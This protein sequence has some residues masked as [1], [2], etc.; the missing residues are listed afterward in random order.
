MLLTD[1]KHS[2]LQTVFKDLKDE[3]FEAVEAAFKILEEKAQA[4]FMHGQDIIEQVLVRSLDMRYWKQSY[5]LN[6]P[7]RNGTFDIETLKLAGKAFT[8]R[9]QEL[10]GF[11]EVM[12]RIKIIN[13]RLTAFGKV[14]RPIM[15]KHRDCSEN[16]NN[17]DKAKKGVRSTFIVDEKVSIYDR[18]KLNPGAHLVGPAIIEAKD[19]TV[20]IPP[21]HSGEIDGF[22]NLLLKRSQ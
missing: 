2:Y 9:H 5:V 15:K 1:F 16:C 21:R 20:W 19:T 22:E 14:K 4:D 8:D 17:T 18:D 11:S 10:Y 7:I 3:P 13:A 12:E 6:I